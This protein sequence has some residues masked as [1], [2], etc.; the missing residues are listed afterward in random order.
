MWSATDPRSPGWQHD[1]DLCGVLR[2][3]CNSVRHYWNAFRDSSTEFTDEFGP[4]SII[5]KAAEKAFELGYCVDSSTGPTTS[6][7]TTVGISSACNSFRCI[8]LEVFCI[9]VATKV[10]TYTR[11]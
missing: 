4:P 6:G 1:L 10:G 11:R 7:G 9:L 5:V 2:I 3:P 8:M